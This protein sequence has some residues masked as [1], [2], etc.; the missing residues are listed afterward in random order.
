MSGSVLVTGA[1][2]FI[3]SHLCEALLA[4]GETV[5]GVDNFDPY[6]SAG[7]KRANLAGMQSLPR[8]SFR[9]F[10]VQNVDGWAPVVA[11]VDRIVH[12]AALAGVCAPRWNN[13]CS[14]WP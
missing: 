11:G 1:A 3:G 6:Y 10:D 2:G 9:E 14:M 8:F 13:R 4:R 5:V 7:E 12:L